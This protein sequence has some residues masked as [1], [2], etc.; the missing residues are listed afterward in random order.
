MIARYLTP[1]E[2]HIHELSPVDAQVSLSSILDEAGFWSPTSYLSPT[3]F[4]IPSEI[5]P[6]VFDTSDTLGGAIFFNR[7]TPLGL[8]YL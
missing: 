1:F 5:S 3:L 8:N 6:T 7:V 2:S 4:A